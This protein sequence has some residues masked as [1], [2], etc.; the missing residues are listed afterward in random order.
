MGLILVLISFPIFFSSLIFGVLFGA[1]AFIGII[2]GAVFFFGGIAVMVNSHESQFAVEVRPAGTSQSRT[3]RRSMVSQLGGMILQKMSQGKTVGEIAKESGVDEAVIAEKVQNL[4][5][6]GF[7]TDAGKLTEK[8]FEGLQSIGDSSFPS[9]EG[10]KPCVNCGRE[11]NIHAG[12]CPYCKTWQPG[13]R[14]P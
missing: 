14:P 2:L 12:F 11:L 9:Q 3:Q 1:T 5:S 10:T 4:R 6:G 13:T 8:G 7:L